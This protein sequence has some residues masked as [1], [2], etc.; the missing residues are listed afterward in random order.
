MGHLS[1]TNISLEGGSYGRQKQ[2]LGEAASLS[3]PLVPYIGSDDVWSVLCVSFDWLND[4]S[5]I[6]L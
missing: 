3:P 4:G 1:T 2:E 6:V 5:V